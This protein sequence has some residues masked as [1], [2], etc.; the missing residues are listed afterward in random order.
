MTPAVDVYKTALELAMSGLGY[1]D[2]VVELR[3]Q[4]AVFSPHYVKM[5]VLGK[6]KIRRAAT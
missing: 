1:E 3:K 6:T 2:V 5:L 4:N